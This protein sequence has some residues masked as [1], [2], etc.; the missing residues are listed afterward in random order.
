MDG[1][2]LAYTVNFNPLPSSDAVQKKKI[3]FRGSLQ[4]VLLQKKVISRYLKF[5]N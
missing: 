3:S 5:N 2:G 1:V 4:S